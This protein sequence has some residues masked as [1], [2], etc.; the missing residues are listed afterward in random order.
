MSMRTLIMAAQTYMGQD[1]ARFVYQRARFFILEAR[2]FMNGPEISHRR[3][4]KLAS[5]RSEGSLTLTLNNST[6]LAAL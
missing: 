1:V 6:Q 2:I 3:H 5:L 4:G